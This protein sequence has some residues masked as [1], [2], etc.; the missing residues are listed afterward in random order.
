MCVCVVVCAC[1][2]AR[3]R[4]CVLWGGGE[5]LTGDFNSGSD[6]TGL[7]DTCGCVAYHHALGIWSE[8]ADALA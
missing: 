1:V 5:H 7:T 2:R 4:V 8:T 6:L 3:A